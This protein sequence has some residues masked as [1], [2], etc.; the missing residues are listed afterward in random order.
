MNRLSD[1]EGIRRLAKFHLSN[2]TANARSPPKTLAHSG[3]ALSDLSEKVRI[4]MA[5]ARRATAIG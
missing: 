5:L 1:D 4:A 3:V 2:I